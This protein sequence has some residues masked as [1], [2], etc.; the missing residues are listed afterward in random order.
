M[1][2]GHITPDM[3]AAAGVSEADMQKRKLIWERKQERLVDTN[4][5]V[6][7]SSTCQRQQK[8]PKSERY[9]QSPP[10]FTLALTK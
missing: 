2:E 5:K 9:S 4:N 8:Q 3:E 6:S 7:P 1:C 10:R